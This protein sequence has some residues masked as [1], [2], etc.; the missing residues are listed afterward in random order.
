M[1]Y[2]SGCKLEKEDTE[3][4]K[5]ARRISGLDTYCKEC[6]YIKNTTYRVANFEKV[7]TYR[8]K[9]YASHQE[10][11]KAQMKEYAKNNPSKISE[12]SARAKQRDKRLQKT[13]G[14]SSS[15]YDSILVAQN[16]LCAICNQP[17]Q[18]QYP[19]AVDHDHTTGKVRELLCLRCNTGLGLAFE[20][21]TILTAM[22]M[23]LQKHKDA[24]TLH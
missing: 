13:F 9:Y 16:G 11:E 21:I 15:E 19:L 3:F 23:Y 14:I 2:C 7:S 4:G 12:P 1:K 18:T 10:K 17:N 24:E 5:N 22:I 6:R 8:K 20:N